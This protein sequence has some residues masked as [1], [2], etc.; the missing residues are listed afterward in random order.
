MINLALGYILGIISAT[1]MTWIAEKESKRRNGQ[2][3]KAI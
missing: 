3:N 1:G 2:K